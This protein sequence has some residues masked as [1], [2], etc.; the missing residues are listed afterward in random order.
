M[1]VP[2]ATVQ[3]IVGFGPVWRQCQ[4][5]SVGSSQFGSRALGDGLR[6]GGGVGVGGHWPLR[7]WGPTVV[8]L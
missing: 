4:R 7:L 2:G 5:R 6:D 8:G 1:F 3:A